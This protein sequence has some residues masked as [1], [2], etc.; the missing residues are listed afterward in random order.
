LLD[1]IA[2]W[3]GNQRS[4]FRV[5]SARRFENRAADHVVLVADGVPQIELEMTLLS[6][7]NHFVAEVFGELGQATISSLCTWGPS[8]FTLYRRVLPAGRPAE[9][10]TTLTTPDPTWDAE[11]NY[12]RELCARKA[13]TDLS[14][15]RWIG[16]QIRALS[17]EAVR[18][19]V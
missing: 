9:D 17:A 4:D 16:A 1:T 6:W 8:T 19:T 7:R 5:V 2:F 11:Y 13:K 18:R 15:D 3:F 10:V 12:F 14:K